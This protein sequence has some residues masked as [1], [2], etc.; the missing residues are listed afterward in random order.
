MGGD[1]G[2]VFSHWS[3]SATTWNS[4]L[5]QKPITEYPEPDWETYCD[6]NA[7]NLVINSDVMDIFPKK[8]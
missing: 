6:L 7:K 8:P 2:E 5:K 4:P 1:L 3:I